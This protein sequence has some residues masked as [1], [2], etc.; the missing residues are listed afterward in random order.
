[1]ANQS[2]RRTFNETSTALKIRWARKG[3][4]RMAA[5]EIKLNYSIKT[6]L[7]LNDLS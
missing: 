5:E 6:Q 1:M 4:G 3:S 7:G 2:K